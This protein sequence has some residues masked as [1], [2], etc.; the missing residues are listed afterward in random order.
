MKQ[1]QDEG[2]HFPEGVPEAV[3]WY[4]AHRPWRVADP[5]M[6]TVYADAFLRRLA[7]AYDVPAPSYRYAPRLAKHFGRVLVI[8]AQCGDE[9]EVYYLVETRNASVITLLHEF[10]H[11]LQHTLPGAAER[12]AL[13]GCE[14]DVDAWVSALVEQT[15][16]RWYENYLKT[17]KLVG[18]SR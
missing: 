3:R 13:R 16:P 7:E 8:T 1:M 12:A 6:I 15:N 2:Y 5:N 11:V 9:V 17:G 14:E 4:M 18:G 10:R